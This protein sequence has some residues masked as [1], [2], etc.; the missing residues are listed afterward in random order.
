MNLLSDE[1]INQYGFS[2][3]LGG[4][5]SIG[6]IHGQ[7]WLILEQT[8]DGRSFME[9]YKRYLNSPFPDCDGYSIVKHRTNELTAK[10]KNSKISKDWV[11]KFCAHHQKEAL[12]INKQWEDNQARGLAAKVD[13]K[14]KL[15]IHAQK[16][17]DA[18]ISNV[19]KENYA[20]KK[21][22]FR[23]GANICQVCNG[24][25]G[26]KRCYKCEGTGWV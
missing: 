25:G 20:N 19:M 3:S 21:T 5:V 6:P 24:D 7:P 4:E 14:E 26:V 10:Y 17:A 23:P 22:G 11:L 16:I 15:A 13:E 9:V 1:D 12:E 18:G 8:W 2:I